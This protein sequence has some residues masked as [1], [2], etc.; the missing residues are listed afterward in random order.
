MK[1][2]YFIILAALAVQGCAFGQ[3]VAYHQFPPP[4]LEATG[5]QTI[6]LGVQD[7]RP[8]VLSKNKQENFVGLTRGG[9]GN[10]FDV[11]TATG[12]PLADDFAITLGKAFGSRG[13][14]VKIVRVNPNA[15]LD[16]VMK[17][18]IGAGMERSI[19][20]RFTEW[21][22]DSSVTSSSIHFNLTLQ[23]YDTT[24]Q[25]LAENQIAGREKIETIGSAMTY[26]HLKNTVPVAFNARME[27]LINDPKI[28]SAL[29]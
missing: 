12:G 5:E 1:N 24:G 20:I 25:V 11:V 16:Q 6:A 14:Q 21:K 3:K 7:R 23:V 28:V 27:R 18:I 22:T 15:S 8:Y 29:K 4:R 9:F 19:L 26:A 2:F 13:F 17:S 10:P